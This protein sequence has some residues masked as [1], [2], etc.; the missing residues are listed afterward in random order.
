MAWRDFI[1]VDLVALNAQHVSGAVASVLGFSLLKWVAEK[2]MEAG[3]ALTLIHWAGNIVVSGCIIY[4]SLVI[5][6][7]LGRKLLRVFKEHNGS[8]LTIFAA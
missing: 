7:A 5:L 2:N 4:L 3:W 8:A 6:L 1:D